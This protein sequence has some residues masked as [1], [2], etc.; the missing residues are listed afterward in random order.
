MLSPRLASD[1][2]RSATEQPATAHVFSL[3]LTPP[4]ANLRPLLLPS[5]GLNVSVAQLSALLSRHF[6]PSFGSS[7]RLETEILVVPEYSDLTVVDLRYFQ[8]MHCHGTSCPNFSSCTTKL[9]PTST[10]ISACWNEGLVD[11]EPYTSPPPLNYR[12]DGKPVGVVTGDQYAGQVFLLENVFI[13]GDGLVFDEKHIYDYGYDCQIPTHALAWIFPKLT[14]LAVFDELVSIIHSTGFNYYHSLLETTPPLILLLPFLKLKPELPLAHCQSQD[15][16]FLEAFNISSEEFNLEPIR[17]RELFFARR[18]ILPAQPRCEKPSRAVVAHIRETYLQLPAQPRVLGATQNGPRPGS[19]RKGEE[20]GF[21]SNWT[22]VLGVREGSRGISQW[23]ELYAKLREV[24]PE[25]RIQI[26]DGRITPS[27]TR[28]LFSTARFYFAPHGAGLANILFM[29]PNGEVLEVAPNYWV[30]NPHN[31]IRLYSYL[32]FICDIKYTALV[33]NGTKFSSL[34][35]SQDLVL[36]AVREIMARIS[37]E[38]G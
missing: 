8:G 14:F 17:S 24:L 4:P 1:T 34:E 19:S 10:S 22:I 38:G 25:R 2:P 37:S 9:P 15:L 11:E 33:G 20:D 6:P 16:R 28:K 5:T 35:I 18:L 21:P 30:K 3:A 29:P 32:A 23:G 13:T 7:S 36:E 31:F 27:A 12:G 26:F